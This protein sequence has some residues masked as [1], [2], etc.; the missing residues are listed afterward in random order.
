MAARGFDPQ[1]LLKAIIQYK[2]L[3][4]IET[5][6]KKKYVETQSEVT[7]LESLKGETSKLETQKAQIELFMEKHAKLEAQGFTE[8]IYD[9]LLNVAKNYDG[10]ENLLKALDVYQNLQ[11]LLS[12]VITIQSPFRG[13]A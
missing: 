4:V 6:L 2:N 8:Q 5:E 13:N 3:Q 10:L 7:R 1:S 11:Q 12:R 9:V